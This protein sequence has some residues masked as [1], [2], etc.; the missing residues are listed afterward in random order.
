VGAVVVARFDVRT[1]AFG[2]EVTA[3][4]SPVPQPPVSLDTVARRISE[5]GIW[6]E[7][8]LRRRFSTLDHTIEPFSSLRFTSTSNEEDLP[9]YD[10][11]DRI[12]DR[13][14]FTYG[15][16]S[17]FLFTEASTGRNSELARLSLSQTYNV[18]ERVIDDHFSDVDATLG[19][20]PTRDVSF[21]GLASYNLGIGSLRGAAATLSLERFALPF[22]ASRRSQLDAAYRFVRRG[23]VET[24]EDGLETLEARTILA[25]TERFAIG[26][27]GRYDFVSDEFVESGG[28]FRIESSCRCWTVDVGVVNRVNPDETQFR[29]EVDLGGLG[30]IGSSALRYRTMGLYGFDDPATGARRYGW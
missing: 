18:E 1:Y 12:D 25:L 28:G 26:L 27:N 9:L 14:T 4:P 5:P 13:T 15:T 6:G 3:A 24:A 21:S 17:R 16:A 23:A 10:T 29:V 8:G 19:I 11:I 20:R 7:G 30:S 2:P 22:V